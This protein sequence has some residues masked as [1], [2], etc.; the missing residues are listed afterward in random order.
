MMPILTMVLKTDRRFADVE[1]TRAYLDGLEN[2]DPALLPYRYALIDVWE[3]IGGD[4]RI[5]IFEQPEV[6]DDRVLLLWLPDHHR[7]ALKLYDRGE[8]QW[9]DAANPRDALRWFHDGGI[10]G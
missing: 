9:S 4:A 5:E 3:Q 1:E 8:W 10:Q 7:A 6:G 2:K